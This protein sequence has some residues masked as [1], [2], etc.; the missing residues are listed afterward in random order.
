MAP[1]PIVVGVDGSA[2]SL[3]AAA[4][5]WK[6]AQAARAPCRLVHAMADVWTVDGVPEVPTYSPELARVLE[7]NAR[8][9]L[10][11][12]LSEALPSAVVAELEIRVGRAPLVLR[13]VAREVGAQLVVVGGKH[14]GPLARGFGGSTAHY[15]VRTLD[16]P[17]LVVGPATQPVERVLAAVDLSNVAT[18]T[19][20]AARWVARMLGARLRVM[21]VV[22]PIKFPTVVPLTLDA[23]A[24][25]RRSVAA[26]ERL[27]VP[28][29]EVAEGEKV[30]RR[31]EAAA[32]VE[33]EAAGWHAGLIVVGSHGKGWLDRALVGSTTERLLNA[34]PASLLIVP[35]VRAQAGAAAVP[36]PRQPARK[37]ARGAKGK[38]HHE[39]R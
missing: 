14:H 27:T 20:D 23:D 19:L 18:V 8:T 7:E 37:R 2:P 16:V 32:A 35:A 5:G 9:Q 11:A 1:K 13:E 38:V 3:R 25:Y 21:H 26:F 6:I 34:L 24:F 28:L 39:S 33:A 29:A 17:L 30:T 22:E 31:G 12:A 10:T 4:L 15:L 36:P